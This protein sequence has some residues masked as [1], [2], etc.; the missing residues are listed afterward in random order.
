[1]IEGMLIAS[2]GFGFKRVPIMSN[3]CLFP[4]PLQHCD[5]GTHSCQDARENFVA[6]MRR[7]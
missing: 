6:P 1:M 3:R 2:V 5:V 4:A 7:P